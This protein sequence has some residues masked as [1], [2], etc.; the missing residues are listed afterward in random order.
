MIVGALS[1]EMLVLLNK[2]T[3]FKSSTRH[4]IIYD[5]I[6]LVT[7]IFAYLY[8]T[9]KQFIE[10]ILLI[11]IPYLLLVRN[12]KIKYKALIGERYPRWF[13]EKLSTKIHVL[14]TRISLIAIGLAGI[15][16]MLAPTPKYIVP[17]FILVRTIQ[18]IWSIWSYRKY[19]NIL[20]K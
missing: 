20:P 7:V 8:L 6:H 10:V 16:S 11:A 9:D 4:I 12:T 19:Y 5:V 3:T 14:E 13:V 17:V 18:S 2:I 1:T 15:I